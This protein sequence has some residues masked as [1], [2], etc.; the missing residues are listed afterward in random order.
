VKNVDHVDE[1]LKIWVQL[2]SMLNDF[3][4]LSKKKPDDA[5]NKF[6]LGFVNTIIARCNEILEEGDHPFPDFR[7]FHEDAVPSNS[8]VALVLSQ[9]KACLEKFHYSNTV[10]DSAADL[11]YW[12]I[13]SKKSRHEAPAK[14]VL[15]K[16]GN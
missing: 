7:A 8:D 10:Y 13:N 2:N 15:F 5:V 11:T 1:F 4:E 6:K 16:S 14:N 9:Y 3:T 12:V